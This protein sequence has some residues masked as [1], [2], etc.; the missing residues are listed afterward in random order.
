MKICLVFVFSKTKP[1]DKDLPK[2]TQQAQDK[3]SSKASFTFHSVGCVEPQLKL[4][5]QL[6]TSP[7]STSLLLHSSGEFL[8]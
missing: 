1:R 5:P 2:V 8:W 4:L 7:S 3:A 6:G